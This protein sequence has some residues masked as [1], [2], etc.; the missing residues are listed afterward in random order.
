MTT[1]IRISNSE[2]QTFK[3]CRRKWWLSYYRRLKKQD[4]DLTGPLAF[5]SRIHLALDIHYTTGEPLLDV[6]RRLVEAD[7]VL[8]VMGGYNLIEYD[9]EADLGRI[10]LEG[11]LEWNAEE[12]IDDN[13]EII[14]TEQR[15]IVPLLD[16]RVELMAKLD[17]RVRRKSDNVRLYRDWKT[18]ASFADFIRT[19]HMSEQMLTYL[20][21][22]ILQYDETDRCDGGIFT[23]FKKVK[24]TPSAKP[25][26][27][28]QIEVRHNVFTLRTFWS[29]LHGVL[30]DVIAVRD[31]LDAKT[32]P[33]FVAYPTPTRDC[34]WYCPFFAI[35]P[36]FDDGS[37]VEE[38]LHDMFT[39]G[40]PYDYYEDAKV[41][42]V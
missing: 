9:N 19:S 5:G 25:P 24:R 42:T 28:Q 17:M 4:V 1:P 39:E 18:A 2:I 6:W 26:F 14:S 37:A 3:K 20:L 41:V 13:L 21:I 12:G 10:M 32:D 38:A 23:L 7:R 34:T 11:Y 27:Y 33:H 35:C 31:A 29:R 16:N 30:T 22:E 15:L 8:A 40:D 36:L